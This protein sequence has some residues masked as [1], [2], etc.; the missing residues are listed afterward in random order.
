VKTSLRILATVALLSVLGVS[1]SF[2]LRPNPPG[3]GIVV[4][5][6]NGAQTPTACT[7]N[8]VLAWNGSGTLG[9]FQ[10]PAAA[11]QVG[12][13]ASRPAATGSGNS[14]QCSDIPVVYH[15]TGI[16][17]WTGVLSR[18]LSP[19]PT[20]S[21]YTA[22]GNI[23]AYQ[24]ADVVRVVNL[25]DSATGVVLLPGSL[26][27]ASA[28][29]ATMHV[30]PLQNAGCQYPMIALIVSNGTSS[31]TSVSYNDGF[32]SA[33]NVGFHITRDVINTATRQNLY[34]EIANSNA[35]V[36]SVGGL[37]FRILNDGVTMNFQYSQDGNLYQSVWGIDT[38]SGLTNYG[39]WLGVEN[40]APGCGWSQVLILQQALTSTLTAPPQAVTASTGNGVSPMVVTVADASKYFP[41]DVVSVKGMAGNTAANTGSNNGPTNALGRTITAIN[42]GTNQISFGQVTGTGTWTSGGVITLLTR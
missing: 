6:T 40:N 10:Q 12:P 1:A 7:A 27:Q 31:G 24:E 19:P 37:F 17:V 18:W 39:L 38:P 20:A 42:Y 16:G 9:C 3:S 2:A 11:F 41:G 36:G 21:S 5:A 32:Y 29:Q 14:Y 34:V 13:A 30:I 33:P 25:I 35:F 28:W 15:D 4:Q 22:V 8:Q 26:P 23:A